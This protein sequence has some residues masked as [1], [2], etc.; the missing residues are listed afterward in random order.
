HRAHHHPHVGVDLKIEVGKLSEPV[1]V[2]AETP[3]LKTDRTDTGRIIESK[4]VSELPLTFNRNFQSLMQTVPGV[5][6]PHREHSQFFN[7]QDS[8]RFEVNGQPGMAS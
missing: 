7:S 4:M 1:Q 5:S 6:R 2:A 8:L 3:M